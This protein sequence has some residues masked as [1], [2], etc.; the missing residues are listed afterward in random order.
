VRGGRCPPLSLVPPQGKTTTV[1]ELI[2]RLV[3][4][5][6]STVLACAPSNVATD[7][8][9]ERLVALNRAV[10]RAGAGEGGRRARKGKLSK[11][12]RGRGGG[13]AAAGGAGAVRALR[14]VRVGHPARV[15][16]SVLSHS[17]DALVQN[18]DE[19]A[20]AREVRAELSALL[21]SRRGGGASKWR[22]VSALR[23]ELR[24]REEEATA[25]V[26]R[27]ADVV[28]CTCV[29]AVSWALRS[30]SGQGR[31]FDTVVVDEAGQALEAACWLPLLRGRRA[32]LAGDHKQLPPTVKS[33]DARRE[34]LGHTLFER[35]AAAYGDKVVHTLTTQYRMHQDICSWASTAM[36]DGRLVAAESAAQNLL[37]DLPGVDSE[38]ELA[39]VPLLLIDTA[40]CDGFEESSN[41]EDGRSKA[42]RGEAA[43]AAAYLDEL[44][45]ATT[46]GEL[47]ALP[48]VID[49]AA[50]D[51][52]YQQPKKT[53]ASSDRVFSL[54]EVG[55]IA[56][57][58]AQVTLLRERLAPYCARG[59]EIS[60]VDGFQGREK[61][62]IIL[63]MTRSNP[64]HEVG[65]LA[66]DR[67][68]NVAVTRA[69][70]QCVV[71]ADSET[72]GS[73]PLLASLLDHCSEFGLHRSASEFDVDVSAG[74]QN[75]LARRIPRSQIGRKAHAVADG[76]SDKQIAVDHSKADHHATHSDA[77]VESCKQ[78]FRARLLQLTSP[79][80]AAAA[81]AASNRLVFP[82]T[83]SSFERRVL[84]SLAEELQL[85]HESVGEGTER[86]IH[87]WQSSSKAGKVD[88]SGA[89]PRL[90][91]VTILTVNAQDGNFDHY[92]ET[93][94]EPAPAR[95]IPEVAGAVY[96]LDATVPPH[97]TTEQ[98]ADCAATSEPEPETDTSG[99][100]SVSA[101]TIVDDSQSQSGAPPLIQ[102][103]VKHGKDTVTISAPCV[104]AALRAAVE[105]ATGVTVEAQKLIA[106]GKT[107]TDDTDL[108]KAVG[109]R[110][111]AKLLL[112]ASPPHAHAHAQGQGQKRMSSGVATPRSQAKQPMLANPPQPTAA[113]HAASSL[114]PRCEV[115]ADRRPRGGS[116]SS[117]STAAV[118][119]ET[120]PPGAANGDRS[121]Q[122]VP[123]S[124]RGD[125]AVAPPA[126]NLSN[127]RIERVEAGDQPDTS[128]QAAVPAATTAATAAATAAAVAVG[129]L[130]EEERA[131]RKRVKRQRQKT[132]KAEAA[133]ADVAAAKAAAAKEDVDAVMKEL[134]LATKPGCCAFV[135][136]GGA[137]LPGKQC[138]AK[139]GTFGQVCEFCRLKFC[140]QHFHAEKHGCAEALR[141]QGKAARMVVG[142]AAG[143]AM[144]DVRRGDL[145]RS[146]ASRVGAAATE[147]QR[148]AKPG[149]KKKKKR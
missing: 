132:A 108:A 106:K 104:L 87:I 35:L 64:Q 141:A 129:P 90:Q 133:A 22:E 16:P 116:S 121:G 93:I 118:L 44:I 68:T 54:C 143:L 9:V 61:E 3:I 51:A 83:L 23:K 146:L 140:I 100:D 2:R 50:D 40:G 10:D 136:C 47:S 20:L 42:N 120:A 52:G 110:T 27:R 94:V 32:V 39:A 73:R 37:A 4:L 24:K 5:G 147:R 76:R 25:Q 70:R 57:Y 71:I 74:V 45:E 112:M 134:G 60:T 109:S 81:A 113:D 97:T 99:V 84:H 46:W 28:V 91:H 49:D 85:Q 149:K 92:G 63:S 56:P 36:Y 131:E 21:Q 33:E 58:N 62:V 95:L 43:L 14:V 139:V 144:G 96:S 13:A 86:C 18:G 7:N 67:R 122:G 135:A 114:R 34:G 105:V 125:T 79:G 11:A 55:V 107:L 98:G 77:E 115:T 29:G 78:R 137:G 1:I 17:L 65:F 88:G 15:S 119:V 142:G 66:E 31:G 41:G 101:P 72:V 75:P 8:L 59:L 6:G 102:W 148:K 127:G 124:S 138:K 111:R 38:C 53:D 89:E 19:Q 145:Q 26:L 128:M 123:A 103:T 130:T 117:S 12:A 80:E 30:L 126:S 82:P 48:V 69:K